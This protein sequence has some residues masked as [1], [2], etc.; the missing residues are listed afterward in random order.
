[1]TAESPPDASSA[2]SGGVRAA[3]PRHALARASR[4][5]ERHRGRPFGSASPLAPRFPRP[6]VPHR[7]LKQAIEADNLHTVCEEANCPN[8]GECWGA[9]RRRS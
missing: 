7:K 9:A 6:A 3:G 8:V 2:S 1:M 5:R 4:R